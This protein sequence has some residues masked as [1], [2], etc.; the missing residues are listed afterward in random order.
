MRKITIKRAA[1]LLGKGE[2]YVRECIKDG[3]L[4]IGT[5]TQLPGSE[6]WNFTI[7]PGALAEYL[8]CSVRELYEDVHVTEESSPFTEEQIAYLLRKFESM[9]RGEVSV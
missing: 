5:A 8:G 9:L 3:S 1:Q 6:R 4:P 7:S 2:L